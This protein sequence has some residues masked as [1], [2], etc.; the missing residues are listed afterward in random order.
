MA[1]KERRRKKK[2][3]DRVTNQRQR[4][5]QLEISLPRGLHLLQWGYDL[6]RAQSDA[7][8][9]I[10]SDGQIAMSSWV[11]ALSGRS[12]NASPFVVLF[13]PYSTSCEY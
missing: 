7:T 6:F 2:A 11:P 10:E 8:G 13:R 4:Q 9:E 1:L 12:A 5:H 3:W